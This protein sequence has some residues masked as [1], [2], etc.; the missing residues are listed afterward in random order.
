[1]DV[2]METEVE[3]FDLCLG[4]FENITHNT[5]MIFLY[6]GLI[7]WHHKPP[8]VTPCTIIVAYYFVLEF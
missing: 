4:E 2:D 3:E 1:M 6:R 7:L 8:V 5:N